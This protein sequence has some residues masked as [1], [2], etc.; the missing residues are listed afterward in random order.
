MKP[1]H[2]LPAALV[3]ALFL[4]ACNSFSFNR[5][6]GDMDTGSFGNATME[7]TLLATGQIQPPISHDKYDPSRAGTLLN[8]K[9]AA[10]IWQGYLAGATSQHAGSAATTGSDT[11]QE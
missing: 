5:E 10:V 7:N 11:S 4:S 9:Y 2:T 6:S 1:I 3:A 8:G